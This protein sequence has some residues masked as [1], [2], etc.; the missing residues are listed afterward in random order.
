[1]QYC[2]LGDEIAAVNSEDGSY[3]TLRGRA[4]SFLKALDSK[5]PLFV[6]TDQALDAEIQQLIEFGL[7][8]TATAEP[9]T[10]LA[11]PV[12]GERSSEISSWGTVVADTYITASESDL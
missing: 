8:V 2:D 11:F 10:V 1:M 7:V 12:S 6:E 3:Y 4:A 9:G 5:Q